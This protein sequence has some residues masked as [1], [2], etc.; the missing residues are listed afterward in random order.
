MYIVLKVRDMAEYL[1]IDPDS[2]PELLDI[3]RMAV[4]APIP[5]GWQQVDDAD[6]FTT[7]RYVVPHLLAPLLHY[8]QL[9]GSKSR[10]QMA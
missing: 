10:T 7:F 4:A 2:E 5:P 9:I 3:A 8:A 6:G 1:G